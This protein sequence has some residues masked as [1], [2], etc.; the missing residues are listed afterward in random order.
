MGYARSLRPNP[1]DVGGVPSQRLVGYAKSA[2]PPYV[3]NSPLLPSAFCIL[4]SAPN[5]PRFLRRI[6]F[7]FTSQW[8]KGHTQD[9][10]RLDLI[11]RGLLDQ[12]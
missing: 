7:V 1:A 4:A 11:V 2:N 9:I 5:S 10:L 8:H 3:S 12:H 6:D